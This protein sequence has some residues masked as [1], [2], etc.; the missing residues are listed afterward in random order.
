VSTSGD[1]LADPSLLDVLSVELDMAKTFSADIPEIAADVEQINQQVEEI[2]TQKINLQTQYESL[3]SAID[4][5]H[6]S[7]QELENKIVTE[8]QEALNHR[9]TYSGTATDADGYEFKF[10]LTIGS[11]IKGSETELINQAWQNVGG[12]GDMPLTSSFTYKGAGGGSNGTGTI[13]PEYAV[14]VFG[15]I[16]VENITPDFDFSGQKT[17]WLR[18]PAIGGNGLAGLAYAIQYSNGTQRYAGSLTEAINMKSNKW[19]PVPFV[20]GVIDVFSPNFPDGNP[21]LD[22]LHFQFTTASYNTRGEVSLNIQPIDI[23]LEKTW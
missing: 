20:I 1:E 8:Q 3:S 13:S 15:T 19:G 7:K 17:I 14:Y 6:K 12:S 16:G 5:V 4:A 2:N 11:W 9:D 18:L 10:T 22:D 23:Y 21:A